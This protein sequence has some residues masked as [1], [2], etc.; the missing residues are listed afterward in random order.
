MLCI[1]L[2]SPAVGRDPD[3]G[4]FRNEDTPALHEKL[5]PLSTELDFGP[6]RYK[7]IAVEWYVLNTDSEDLMTEDDNLA[8]YHGC[9]QV[10]ERAD[11]LVRGGEVDSGWLC[12]AGGRKSMSALAYSAAIP[13]G[14]LLLPCHVTVSRRIEDLA[15][16][17]PGHTLVMHPPAGER[18]LIELPKI[19]SRG[20]RSLSPDERGRLKTVERLAD[21]TFSYDTVIDEM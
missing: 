14:P 18:T 15:K 10:M 13:M 1:A 9:L 11:M 8:Y 21:A 3:A 12:L 16:T 19:R 4:L 7:T 2:P 17:N 5:G 20:L 6:Q